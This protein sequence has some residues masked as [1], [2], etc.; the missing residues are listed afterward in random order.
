M[1]V[2]DDVGR[3]AQHR[4]ALHCHRQFR[5]EDDD[6][7]ARVGRRFVRIHRLELGIEIDRLVAFGLYIR[8]GFGLRRLGV[9]EPLNGLDRLLQCLLLDNRRLHAERLDKMNHVGG[10]SRGNDL[11]RCLK[12]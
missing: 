4:P 10:S 2:D 9:M 7:T 12:H 5:L 6:L 11:R 8:L 3:G 1:I